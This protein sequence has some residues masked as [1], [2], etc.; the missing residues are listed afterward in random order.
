MGCSNLSNPRFSKGF[1]EEKSLQLTRKATLVGKEKT[2]IVAFST[3][4][5]ELDP[6]AFPKGEVFLVEV[7]F[8]NESIKPK[9]VSFLLFNKKPLKIK[10]LSKKDEKLYKFYR[11]SSW[12]ELF[13]IYFDSMFPVDAANIVLKM[14]IVPKEQ[15]LKFDY[16]YVVSNKL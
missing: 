6:R 16:S 8:E 2:E 11:H 15:S 12:S 1:Y 9:D 14:L 5:S 10:R 7:I 3:Y 4:V 13:L